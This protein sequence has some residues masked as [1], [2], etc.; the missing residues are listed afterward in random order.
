MKSL[1]SKPNLIML[2]L[3][4][5]EKLRIET[6]KEIEKSYRISYIILIIISVL[7]IA[8]DIING[9]ISISAILL[10]VPFV[11]VMFK[12]A[13][14]TSV[15][16]KDMTFVLIKLILMM[17]LNLA[18]LF[19][20]MLI[21]VYNSWFILFV[22]SIF[23]LHISYEKIKKEIFSYQTKKFRQIFKYQY[24]QPRIKQLGYNYY[25]NSLPSKSDL[26]PSY[27]YYK[28]T[29]DFLVPNDKVVGK[30]DSVKFT[31]NDLGDSLFFCADFNK[32]LSVVSMTFLYSFEKPIVLE[33]LEEIKLDNA[34]FNKVFK[35]YTNRPKNAWY[36]LTP[37][38]MQ[39]LLELKKIVN[40]PINVSFTGSKIYIAILTG[41][42]SFEPDINQ[43]ILIHNPTHYIEKDLNK[44]FE[45]IETLRLNRKIW[46][47]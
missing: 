9:K 4:K 15:K 24:L 42:D 43:S 37:L 17:T 6:L 14:F 29:I 27:M 23:S 18:F 40:C 26:Y 39:Q 21:L 41:Y 46:S 44:I 25:P 8:F 16:F 47:V 20:L 3:E 5:V 2:S 36:I 38:L 19:I 12:I 22:A 35:V 31:L 45:I 11:K 13:L 28:E 1:N 7:L 10:I 30:K 32:K 33:K 34:D